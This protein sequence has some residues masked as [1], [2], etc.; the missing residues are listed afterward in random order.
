M[1]GSRA[2]INLIMQW[3][4]L[5]AALA[6]ATWTVLKVLKSF[7]DLQAKVDLIM[8]NHLPHMNDEIEAIRRELRDLTKWLVNRES[9]P[10][11]G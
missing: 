5:L 8:E 2:V 9:G 3:C 11:Q 1:E 10:S 4:G 6:G 7:S